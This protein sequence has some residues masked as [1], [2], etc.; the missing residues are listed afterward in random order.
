MSLL[1][2]ENTD[3][4]TQQG[5]VLA[6]VG[7][8][9]DAKEA[10]T[11][12][13]LR[14]YN[15]TSLINLANWSISHKG[16]RP[17][18]LHRP[19]NWQVQ[20]SSTKRARPQSSITRGLK[21]LIDPAANQTSESP[22]SSSSDSKLSPASST[23]ISQPD[24]R[25][26]P[27][28]R[29]TDETSWDVIEDLPLRWATDFV[30]L[31][32]STSRLAN[33]SVISY[34]LWEDETRKGQG[35]RLLAIATKNN[36]FLYETPRG[37]RAFRFVKVGS[38]LLDKSDRF[39]LLKKEFYIPL[40]PRN[41]TFFKQS[42]Q[43]VNRSLSDVTPSRFFTSHRR[44]DSTITVR[45]SDSSRASTPSFLDYGTHLSLFVIFDKKASWIRLV[46]SAVG[47]IEF[48]DRASENPSPSSRKSRMSF[49]VAH[50][51]PKWIL[52]VQCTLPLPH[53]PGMTKEIILVTR[54]TNTHIASSPLPI[55]LSSY[56]PL[57]VVIWRSPPTSI[58]A[59]VSMECD[60]SPPFLQLIGL[61]G[62]NGIEVQ[63]VPL[64][65]LG[66]GKSN[67]VYVE[68]NRKAEEDLGGDSG[69]LCIGGHWDRSHHLFHRQRLS[70]SFTASSLLSAN[71]FT[72]MES[73]DILEK[74]KKEEGV[75]AWCRKGLEDWRV[76]WIGGPLKGHVEVDE[77]D[78][79]G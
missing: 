2:V 3:K 63:E 8:E 17:L 55:G 70:R 25:L 22:G 1:E 62:E 18:D 20:Q 42:V 10:D 7:P 43:D 76:F 37:E 15:L 33:L 49:D 73:E 34:A 57:E 48:F 28:R 13:T 41:L 36:I 27:N 52:P 54:G 31:A 14:M 44:T 65:F 66:N 69:F 21:S 77:G 35:G 9:P 68:E 19:S 59:R 23:P 79:N 47:E 67:A 51:S 5:V 40:Q 39:S 71:S 64:S 50:P 11:I 78:L 75:Y 72:S 45:G 46:D 12:R 60:S 53:R 74:M 16:T 26:S 38:E 6:L 32:T 24:G 30:S 4:G 56:A 29:D 61:G 58:S